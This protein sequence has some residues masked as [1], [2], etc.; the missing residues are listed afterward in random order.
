MR[1]L[2]KKFIIIIDG[3]M[4]SGKTTVATI[5]HKKLKRTAHIGL[6]RIK[7]FISDFKRIPE[8]NEIIRS[9]VV[10]MTKEYLKQGISVI[11]EQGMRKE[12]IETLKKI[13]MQNDAHFLAYQLTASK[14]V[15]FERVHQRPHLSNRPKVT[16][17]RIE[18]NYKAYLKSHKKPIATLIDVENVTAQ[19]VANRILKDL[20]SGAKG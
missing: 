12:R 17:A 15:L 10:A 18:R 14:S 5:L 11:V 13:A 16:K 9:V 19:Q 4:G 7:W 6:D 20:N 8:D 2:N 3:P 1:V